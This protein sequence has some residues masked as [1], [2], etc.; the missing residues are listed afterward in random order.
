MYLRYTVKWLE[1]AGFWARTQQ[2]HRTWVL[3]FSV[4]HRDKGE[5]EKIHDNDGG[6]VV[7]PQ[8]C[9][10]VC[11]WEGEKSERGMWERERS[12]RVTRGEERDKELPH[13][14]QSSGDFYI[15]PL[16]GKM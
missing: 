14:R 12:E 13:G 11:R 10:W 5:G 3:G 8:V 1:L 16:R 7:F 9:G 4:L 2:V 15:V 6:A